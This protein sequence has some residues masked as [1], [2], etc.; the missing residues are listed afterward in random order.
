M[1]PVFPSL[2]QQCKQPEIP[3]IDDVELIILA[4]N[5]KNLKLRSYGGSS[6]ESVL[7]RK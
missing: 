7:C 2:V 4:D 1:F 5:Q 3:I 6:S